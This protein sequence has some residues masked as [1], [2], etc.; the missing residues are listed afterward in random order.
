MRPSRKVHVRNL[1]GGGEPFAFSFIGRARHKPEET[2][3]GVAGGEANQP[4]GIAT[5]HFRISEIFAGLARTHAA[6]G[7]DIAQGNGR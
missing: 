7:R 1:A 5:G 2:S 4:I 6:Q 3:F